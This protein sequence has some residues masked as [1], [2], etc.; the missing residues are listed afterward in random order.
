MNRLD[1][2]GRTAVVTGGAAGIGL[3]V[4]Q[5]ARRQRRTRRAVGPRRGRARASG[6]SLAGE[7]HVEALDVAERRCGRCARR[8][9]TA[10]G[11][12]GHRRA[13]VLRGHHRTERRRLASI[14]VRAWKQR[15][16]RQRARAVPVQPRRRA[17]H[18]EARL[19][20]HRQHRVG[21]RQGRQPECV[22]VQRVEGR[23]DRTHQVARQGA[24]QDQHPRQLRHARGGAHGDL[25][26]DDP[27]AHRLH[28]V[29]DPARPL[30]HRGRDRLAGV[31]A[32]VGGC[33]FSTGA[34]FDLSGGR[35]T[36]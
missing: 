23:G 2:A 8:R 30:R 6:R 33:A 21:R 12:R 36:Y 24:R 4:A 25:R 3:A 20:P 26:P 27:A 31:L 1:F 9:A 11:A 32:R 28:A 35:A 29:E 34:V 18:A 7:A 16:R 17:A 5:Q 10:D 22:G 19:R 13:R 14:P 15:V